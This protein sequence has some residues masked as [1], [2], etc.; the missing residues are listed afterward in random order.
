MKFIKPLSEVEKQTLEEAHRNHPQFRARHRA[1]ALLLN[2]RGYSIVQLQ[3][4]FEVGRDTVSGWLDRWEFDGIV[5]LSDE[6]R[7]GRPPIFTLEEQHKFKTFV[8]ENPHQ[9]KEAATRLREEVGKD[10][11]LY[12]YK[13]FLKK[14]TAI[15]GN[16]VDTH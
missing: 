8:D 13:R 1:Q 5:G 3:C 6:A 10:A 16:V 15:P 11:S 9:L 12:T 4:I 14:H 2:A 7:S